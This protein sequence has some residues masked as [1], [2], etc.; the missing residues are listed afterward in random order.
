MHKCICVTFI[1]CN[2]RVFACTRACVLASLRVC[3]LRW[4]RPSAGHVW[5]C[6]RSGTLLLQYR[7][8]LGM[9]QSV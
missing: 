2:P 7:M 4:R 5:Q 6:S 1:K 8:L 3:P 9:W